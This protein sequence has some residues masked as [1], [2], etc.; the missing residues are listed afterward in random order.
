MALIVV[1]GQAKNVGK[2]TLL[3]N[4]IAAFRELRWNAVKITN[5]PH[6]PPGCELRAES[7]SWS[8]WEQV[9][10]T[11]ESDTRRFVQAGAQSAWLIRAE[12][13][14]LEEAYAALRKN[15]PADNNLIVESNRIGS[16]LHPDLFLLMV[17]AGQPEFKSS[18]W[19]RLER[20]DAIVWR[21]SQRRFSGDAWAMIS[22]KPSFLATK[23]E[24][25]PKLASFIRDRLRDN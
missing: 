7:A 20:I 13:N 24:L 11:G 17:D 16:L 21:G 1:G 5:H 22:N 3:L 18:A 19:Q 8:I 2:T 9:S 10:I 14:A 12:D 6:E 25:D 4:I 23:T 15:V